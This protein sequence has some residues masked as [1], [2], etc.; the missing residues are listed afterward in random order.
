MMYAML[1]TRPDLAYGISVLSKFS[2]TPQT[3]HLRAVKHVLRYLKRTAD[4]G[5]RY[6]N[7]E[8]DIVGYSDADWGGDRGDRKSIGG[9]V[10]LY[11]G[12]AISWMGASLEAYRKHGIVSMESMKDGANTL[13]VLKRS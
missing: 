6:T 3:K 10:F 8:G 9:Y 5:L 2:S 13:F 11:P 1:A 12:A 7:I 4:L